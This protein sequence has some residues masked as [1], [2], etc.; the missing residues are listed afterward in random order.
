[1]TSGPHM[2]YAILPKSSLCQLRVMSNEERG[3]FHPVHKFGKKRKKCTTKRQKEPRASSLTT[4]G[5]SITMGSSQSAECELARETVDVAAVFVPES[6]RNSPSRTRIDSTFVSSEDCEVRQQ[7]AEAITAQVSSTSA[8]ERKM[9]SLATESEAPMSDASSSA[10]TYT[11]T[12]LAAVNSLLEFTACC[13]CRRGV[14]IEREARK[15][16][17]AV[18]LR[19]QCSNCGDLGIEWGS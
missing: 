18:K 4:S 9:K 6:G 19:T 12:N 16:G 17:V 2:D 11:V 14:N 8:M 7:Q 1:M 13:V 3:K 5:A 15:F 10:A